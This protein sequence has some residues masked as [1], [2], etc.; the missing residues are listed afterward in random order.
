MALGLAVSNAGNIFAIL[1]ALGLEKPS[2]ELLM[3]VPIVLLAAALEHIHEKSIRSIVDDERPTSSANRP[4]RLAGNFALTAYF[5]ATLV[6][7]VAAA[8]W[9]WN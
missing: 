9:K 3:A 5:V 8:A 4:W 7:C 1:I 2:N 6:L